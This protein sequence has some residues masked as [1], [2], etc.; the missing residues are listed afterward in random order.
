MTDLANRDYVRWDSG[1]IEEVPPNEEEDINETAKMLNEIQKAMYDKHRH[2]F[3]G[4]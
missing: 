3:G 2:C 4:R 1:G